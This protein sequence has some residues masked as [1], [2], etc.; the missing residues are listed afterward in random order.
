M[1]LRDVQTA[2]MLPAW[3]RADDVDAAAAG[4][5]DRAVS[6]MA[7]DLTLLTTWDRIDDL[8]EP[9]L[10]ELAWALSIEWWDP[11]APIEA[12]RAIVRQSDLVHAKKGTPA[13]V[14]S[15]IAAYFDE[16]RVQEWFEYGGQPHH[17]RI[18]TPSAGLVH[19]NLGKFLKL[20][21]KVVRRSSKL[22]TVTVSLE[23]RGSL[24]S[25]AAQRTGCRI[26]VAMPQRGHVRLCGTATSETDHTAVDMTAGKED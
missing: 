7:R 11:A 3:M 1:R 17:Y 21:S 20:L 15:V 8:P 26:D 18:L 22:D 2:R 14:E 9:V 10:D 5:V 4:A 25:G 23:Q 24:Y 6:A 13:A 12:K 16:G 19:Q